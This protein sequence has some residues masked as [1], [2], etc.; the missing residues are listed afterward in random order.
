MGRL[1]FFPGQ[2]KHG[3]QAHEEMNSVT[4]YQGNANRNHNVASLYTC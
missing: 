1:S 4:K 3:Q 2:Y